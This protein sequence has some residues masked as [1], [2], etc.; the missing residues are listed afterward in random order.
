MLRNIEQTLSFWHSKILSEDANRARA[1]RRGVD[2]PFEGRRRVDVWAR[3]VTVLLVDPSQ[4][5]L[6]ANNTTDWCLL[7]RPVYRGGGGGGGGFNVWP[8]HRAVRSRTEQQLQSPPPLSS[9]DSSGQGLLLTPLTML[10]WPVAPTEMKRRFRSGV[11]AQRSELS[12]ATICLTVSQMEAVG[13]GLAQ[14][15]RDPV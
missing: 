1:K 2:S 12:M 10:L 11:E 15:M 8:P 6:G 4:L 3:E 13:S 9:C 14:E 5:R 7:A